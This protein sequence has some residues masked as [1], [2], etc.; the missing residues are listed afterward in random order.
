MCFMR[1]D[2]CLGELVFGETEE[3]IMK[4]KKAA[5]GPRTTS[6]PKQRGPPAA[7]KKK[8]KVAQ[9]RTPAAAGREPEAA[10]GRAIADLSG[11]GD[12]R[13]R[14]SSPAISLAAS[15]S[16]MSSLD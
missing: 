15:D 1:S 2:F 14:D 8:E 16:M 10:E 11:G 6:T 13:R 7:E 5:S 9:V 3:S 12:R 4:T